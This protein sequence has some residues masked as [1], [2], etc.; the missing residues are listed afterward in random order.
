MRYRTLLFPF[1]AAA[2][3][4]VGCN[5][6]T[7]KTA[8]PVVSLKPMAKPAELAVGTAYVSLEDGQ[9]EVRLEVIATSTAAITYQSND[10]CAFALP[11]SGFAP[12]T[13][14]EN[15][16]GSRGTQQVR[17]AS[18][19]PWPLTVGQS[20]RC[21]F[22]GRN[23]NGDTWDGERTSTVE[24]TARATAPIGTYDTFKV[25]CEE[26]NRTRTY[27]ASPELGVAVMFERRDKRT[28]ETLKRKL[29]RI[30]QERGS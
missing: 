25:V 30:E 21:S 15:C 27:Y 7:T 10:G 17:L 6:Q 29:V 3:L 16:E 5:T 12:V 19:A 22:S 9:K 14:F 1:C 26:P 4:L 8:V 23:D 2:T 18:G 11:T 24:G 13:V 20:W 28:E